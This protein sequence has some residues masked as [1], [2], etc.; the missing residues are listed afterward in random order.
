MHKIHTQFSCAALLLTLGAGLA[1]L[2]GCGG[3]SVNK[4]IIPTPASGPVAY[5]LSASDVV[6]F[7]VTDEVSGLALPIAGQDP[8]TFLT[9][10]VASTGKP[11]S[12]I[13]VNGTIPLGFP[14]GGTFGIN[15]QQVGSAVLAGQPGVIFAASLSNGTNPTTSQPVPLQ[16]DSV[17]LT[18]PEAAGF[19]QKLTYSLPTTPT[20]PLANAQYTTAPFTLPFTTPGLHG[21][22]ISLADQLGQTSTTDYQV[23]VVDASTVAV[24]A[25]NITP[26]NADGTAGTT[27]QTINPGDTATITN[28]VTGATAQ[29]TADTQ[30]TVILFTTPGVQKLTVTPAGGTAVTQ[31]LDL[32]TAAGTAVIQ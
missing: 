31:T 15:S 32:T 29:A 5:G 16:T 10:A 9:G 30:G 27:A 6:N 23:V 7:G 3:G 24:F 20:G 21:F 2:S 19:S 22:R 26:D 13:A 17:T 25:Q 8:Q 11:L 12:P 28:P 18:S 4:G 1:A 14:G